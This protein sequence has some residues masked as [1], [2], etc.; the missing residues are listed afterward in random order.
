MECPWQNIRL[1]FLMLA[2][3]SMLQSIQRSV[4]STL[5]EQHW[6]TN[7]IASQ[8]SL[9]DAFHLQ[10]DRSNVSTSS[11][12]HDS[13]DMQQYMSA[14][15]LTMDDNHLWPEWLAYHYTVMPLRRLIVGIDSK[16]QTSSQHIFDR[17]KGRIHISVWNETRYLARLVDHDWEDD[18]AKYIYAQRNLLVRSLENAH[19]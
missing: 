15:V 12:S 6:E 11:T 7:N 10:Q 8:N 17:W 16:S 14:C 18:M 2:I 13:K 1:F 19:P 5:W 3:A 9:D 4:D